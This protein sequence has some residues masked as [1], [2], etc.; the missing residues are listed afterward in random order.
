[1]KKVN[2]S[3]MLGKFLNMELNDALIKNPDISYFQI[4][5]EDIVR[6]I[7]ARNRFAH[8]G[9]FGHALLIAGSRGKMGAAVLGAKACLRAG[10]GLLTVHVPAC[11]EVIIHVALP[12]AM[13]KVDREYNFIT[14]IISTD[15]YNAIAIGPGIRM[16]KSTAAV[17]YDVLK[18]SNKPTVI[19]A[20]A[21]NI[22]SEDKTSLQLIP[23]GSILTPHPKEFDRLTKPSESAYERLQKAIEMAEKLKIYLVLKGAYTSICT[24]NKQCFF[25]PTGNPGMAT[26]G[27]GDVLTGIILGLLAQSYDPLNAAIVG[28]FLHGLAGNIAADK[29]SEESMIASDIIDNL[30]Q[31]FMLKNSK[32]IQS[33]QVTD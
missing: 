11:G 12:E 32:E 33:Q 1:M 23:P 30:G 17:L 6:L 9:N 21:L 25:N 4:E 22:L 29:C 31:A 19:D 28:V 3:N 15:E 8:K 5:E 2:D 24:P 7:P 13:T 18:Y 26:A 14:D 16:E 10:A 27:S 20:D